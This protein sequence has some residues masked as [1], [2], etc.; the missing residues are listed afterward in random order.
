L[1]RFS[2]SVSVP[3]LLSNLRYLRTDIYRKSLQWYFSVAKPIA[4]CPEV[5]AE[6][7]QH[8]ERM[9]GVRLGDFWRHAQ[10]ELSSL[11]LSE[12]LVKLLEMDSDTLSLL[13]PTDTALLHIASLSP[14]LSQPIFT[15]DTKFAGQCRKRQV[16]VLGISNVQNIWEENVTK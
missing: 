1:W 11:G 4:T 5:I 15:E 12:T 13:G 3:T 16:N 2:E 14:N 9:R 6:I 8:A 7:H 10:K